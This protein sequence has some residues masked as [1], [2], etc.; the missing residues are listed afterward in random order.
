MSKF[1]FSLPALLVGFLSLSVSLQYPPHT[2][3]AAGGNLCPISGVVRIAG[4]EAS[5]RPLGGGKFNELWHG[6]DVGL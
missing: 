4:R 5:F 3:Q 6:V 1:F 2:R